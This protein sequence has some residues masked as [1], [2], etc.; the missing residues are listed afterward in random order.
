[1]CTTFK[2]EFSKTFSNF[3]VYI[4]YPVDVYK[5]GFLSLMVKSL[6][7][8]MVRKIDLIGQI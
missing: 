4:K 3:V 6:I 7:E 1:M 2:K 8:F 5:G